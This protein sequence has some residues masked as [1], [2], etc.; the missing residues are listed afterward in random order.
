MSAQ[1]L[2]DVQSIRADFPIFSR[3]IRGRPNVYLDTAS[4]AQKP[5]CVIEAMAEF[6]STEYAN[7]HRGVYYLS[8]RST[9]RYEAVR[10]KAAQ[11][12]NAP[13][14]HEIIFTSGTTDSI[15]LVAATYGREALRSG[16]NVVITA[17]EHHSNIVPWQ[18]ACKEAGSEL[19]VVPITPD[20]E[21]RMDDFADAIND[22][23]RIA[24][25]THCSNVLG[26]IL[27][28]KELVEIA[29]GKGV[30]ILL[31]GAQAAAHMSI[32]V[33][34]LG[35]D[36][37]AFSSHKLYGPN[38]VGVLYGRRE[39]LESMPPYRGGG[40][41][42]RSV[43]FEK[44]TYNDIP[45]KFEA[46][47]PNIAGV[48]GFGAALDYVSSLGMDAIGAREGELLAYAQERMAKVPGLHILGPASGKAAVISF[49]LK[50][51][52]PH[53]IGTILDS[54]GVAIRAGHHCAQPLM[55]LLNVPATAR[56]SFGIY[57]NEEDVDRLCAALLKVSEMFA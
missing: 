1:P 40:D 4:T 12:I 50:G 20:G 45:Y 41:M 17:L 35:C 29:H 8:E 43:T 57:S 2:S 7:V 6:L 44:T 24:A 49:T 13:S 32:D 33:Q 26:T 23:T 27:P 10:A 28:A 3:E 56:A 9:E 30:P 25:I 36:F 34:D 15:N 51:I 19:R 47:T 53:D 54:E 21:V 14:T 5:K 55:E 22:T 46:G 31:D 16:G 11:F 39:L 18:M 37:Y 48:V 52:H 38:G 42:I